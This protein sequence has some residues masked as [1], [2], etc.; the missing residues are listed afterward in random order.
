MFRLAQ[1]SF[2]DEA[3]TKIEKVLPGSFEIGFAFNK[4]TLEED[5]L[6]KKLGISKEK[7]NS[8][9]FD[10]LSELG[11]SKQEISQANDYVCG[12][13]TIEGAPFLKHEHYPVFDCANKCGKKGVRYIRPLAHI[14]MMA[15]GQPFVSGAISKTINLP[16]SAI[17]LDLIYPLSVIHPYT[18]KRF[19]HQIGLKHVWQ[20]DLFQSLKISKWISEG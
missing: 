20:Y 3:V 18:D 17:G 1:G 7:I 13:M 15:S 11:F 9:N 6:V 5:F 8:F 16:N 19:R 10:M 2:T 14:K 4:F 12:T